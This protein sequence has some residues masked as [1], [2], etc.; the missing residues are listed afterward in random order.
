MKKRLYPAALE[1][2]PK[3]TFGAWFPDFP[4]ASPVE[5]RRKKPSRRRKMRWS[6]RLLRWPSRVSRF[7]SRR[8]SA[9]VLPK[10]LRLLAYFIVGV[11]R[12]IR[13]A[14]NV[15]LPKSLIGRVDRRAAE[16]GMSRSAFRASPSPGRWAR[17]RTFSAWPCRLC[18]R[19]CTQRAG[20]EPRNRRPRSRRG[21]RA[22]TASWQCTEIMTL[23]RVGDR[24]GAR[25][26]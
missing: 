19:R 17:L 20:C 16:L 24:R 9:H 1:R 2:G 13:R 25:L 26:V 8:R 18:S 6:R 22:C 3:G 21:K 15:Y 5:S 11:D 14:V 23:C 10:G 7:R 12:R 4:G